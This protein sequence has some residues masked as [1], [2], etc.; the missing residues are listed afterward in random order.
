[1]EYAGDLDVTEVWNRLWNEPNSVLVDVHSAAEWNYVGLPDL[2]SLKRDV[3]CSEWQS[4]PGMARN[5][6]FLA[7]IEEAGI[8]KD[9]VIFLLCRSGVRSKNAAIL[10]TAA[11]YQNC[12][13][14]AGGFEG[15]KDESDHRG[16]I[17]GWKFAGLPWSQG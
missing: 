5:E 16:K 15:D 10:L 3:V 7:E 1:M 9:A 6:G 12:F 8:A 13:N 11:G 17:G 14:V 4:Y 2:S